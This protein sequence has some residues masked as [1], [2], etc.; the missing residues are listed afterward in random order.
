MVGVLL[1]ILILLLIP[2]IWEGFWLLGLVVMALLSL[3][4]FNRLWL[5]YAVRRVRLSREMQKQAF[6]GD[7]FEVQVIAHNGSKLPLPWVVVYD[8]IPSGLNVT[9]RPEWLLSLRSEEKIKLNYRVEC[10][11]RGRYR[12]GPIEGRAGVIF[13][14]GNDNFG[15]RLNWG[16]RSRLTVFPQIF[17]LEQLQ[18][19]SRLPLGNI[20]TRQPL[21]PDPS[22]IAGVRNYEPGDDPRYI[23]WRNTARIGQLQVKQFERTRI[24]PLAVFLD[25]HPP[26][27]AFNFRQAAEASISVAA[28]LMVRAN[29]LR[30]SFGLYSNGNDPGWEDNSY[31]SAGEKTVAQGL[32]RPEM[33][34]KSGTPW[35]YEVLDKLSAIEIKADSPRFEQL[36]GSWSN[37][38]PWGSTIALISFEPYA[39]LITECARIRKAGFTLITIFTARSNYSSQY[40][41]GIE[42]LRAMNLPVFDITYPGELNFAPSK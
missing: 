42:A 27:L 30:Q 15:K 25:L 36:A 31:W 34:P 6:V 32:N 40:P 29:E 1:I 21:L 24:I 20:R 37:T 8:Y 4:L 12:V 38:L 22:R 7:T 13:D 41:A 33:H 19:P 14:G 23:D 5:N 18:L 2:G 26:N 17:A 9:P 39:E 28:S 10:K 11:R 3:L 16:A 35:L